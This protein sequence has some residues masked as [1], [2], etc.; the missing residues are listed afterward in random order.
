MGQFDPF[1]TRESIRVTTVYSTAATVGG[2]VSRSADP[3]ERYLRFG[4]LENF[5]VGSRGQLP[6]VVERR[7]LD[8]GDVTFHRWGGAALAAQAWW[9]AMPSGQII[10]A[11]SV[12][13]TAELIGVIPLLEDMY[14]ADITVGSGSFEQLSA[15]RSRGDADA[16]RLGTERHQLVFAG[17]PEGAEVPDRDVVQRV[18]YRADL[19]CR[20]GGS[21]IRYPEEL[22][23]RPTTLGA[24][25]PYVSVLVGQQDYLENAIFVSAVQVVGAADRLRDIRGRAHEAVAVFRS[26]PASAASTRERRLALEQVADTLSVMEL[27]LS[28]TVEALADLGF[29]IPAL[30][31]E[32]YHETL[33]HSMGLARR[34]STTG[35]MLTR[36]RF[37]IGAELT[38]VQSAEDRADDARRVRTVAAVTFVTTVAGTLGL[39]FS[40]FGINA[41]Q[42]DGGRSIFDRHYLPIYLLVG[43]IVAS[44][45]IIFWV[46]RWR[47]RSRGVPRR[48]GRLGNGSVT[49]GGGSVESGQLRRV[50]RRASSDW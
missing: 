10:A 36:L 1:G 31:L 19:P 42:V 26:E 27:E 45:G 37:A 5:V 32:S 6:Q 11:I 18:I 29:L 48:R 30:R 4:R 21:S 24:V 8:P 46:L 13:V 43:S 25:G 33:Y 41:T 9:F 47:E 2:D 22:N 20:P 15:Q 12:D 17:V 50:V 49:A 7:A 34:S 3:L 14:Y 23:R 35:Q 40:F 39:L 28:F 16:G 38:A 44:A